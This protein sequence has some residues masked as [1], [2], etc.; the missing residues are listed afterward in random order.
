VR[1]ALPCVDTPLCLICLLVSDVWLQ[2]MADH[3]DKEVASQ[4]GQVGALINIRPV[5]SFAG[6]PPTVGWVVRCT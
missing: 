2:T 4:M 6:P 5:L 3:A 1:T